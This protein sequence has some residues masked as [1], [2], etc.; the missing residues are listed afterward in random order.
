MKTY[1]YFL[2]VIFVAVACWSSAAIAQ[3][4]NLG[5]EQV[6][7]GGGNLE[8]GVD[9]RTFFGGPISSV[10]AP[11]GTSFGSFSPGVGGLSFQE[12]S[13]RFLGD[14]TVS[15]SSPAGQT[16]SNFSVLFSLDDV[17]SETPTIVSPLLSGQQ[18]T[19]GTEFDLI[20]EFPPGTT[21]PNG[22]AFSRVGGTGADI[23]SVF[24]DSGANLVS[25][26]TE[27]DPGVFSTT[28]D[29]SA[30]SFQSINDFVSVGPNSDIAVGASFTNLS[31]AVTLTVVPEPN[32]LFALFATMTMVA[33]SR[34]RVNS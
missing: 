14:W 11:D 16:I 30:G 33:C 20:W 26:S 1:R 28:F 27:L 18:G 13:D 12:L 6:S 24:D 25:I 10:E 9:V 15:I 7:T 2:A 29:V 22:R 3:D 17:F 32:A 31:Q 8:Y 4:V 23:D 21:P 34:R 5:F 19:V